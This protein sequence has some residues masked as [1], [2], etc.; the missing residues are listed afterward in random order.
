MRNP[1]DELFKNMEKF[2]KV[3]YKAVEK[4]GLAVLEEGFVW[5]DS[6]E[7]NI[8][9]KAF[10]KDWYDRWYE[11]KALEILSKLSDEEKRK[12]KDRHLG[13]MGTWIRENYQHA[14]FVK[15][16]TIPKL[17]EIGNFLKKV[18][19]K[20]NLEKDRWESYLKDIDELFTN[21]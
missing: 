2:S 20:E 5:A 16:P 18:M 8:R 10:G 19:E 17:R 14:H 13:I 3:D 9:F 4:S 6:D 1:M 11:V 21:A 15:Y 12:L 7:N